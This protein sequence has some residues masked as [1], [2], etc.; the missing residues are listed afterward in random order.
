[1]LIKPYKRSVLQLQSVLAKNDKAVLE[2][3]KCNEKTHSTMKNKLFL[4]L[5]AE[6]LHFSVT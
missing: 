3:F 6:N 5:Y 2:T 1:M 4:L